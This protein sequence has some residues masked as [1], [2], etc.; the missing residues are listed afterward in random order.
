MT[1]NTD[2]R[3]QFGCV[4]IYLGNRAS[5]AVYEGHLVRVSVMCRSVAVLLF[6]HV[7]RVCVNLPVLSWWQL[8]DS[9]E[10]IHELACLVV[11]PFALVLRICVSCWAWNMLAGV[12]SWSRSTS[13]CLEERQKDCS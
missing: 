9:L 4:N 3:K 5:A 7:L 10:V 11:G 8:A 2:G 13:S 1:Y 12:G 6:S